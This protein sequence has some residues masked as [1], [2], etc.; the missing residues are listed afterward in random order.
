MKPFSQIGANIH[1]VGED[2]LDLVQDVLALLAV[3]LLHLLRNVLD[4]GDEP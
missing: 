2:P 3:H 1:P 4:L